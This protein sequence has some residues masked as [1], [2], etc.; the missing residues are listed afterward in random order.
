VLAVPPEHWPEFQALCDRELVEA[1]DLGQFVDSGRLTLR[2]E[3]HVVC[4]LSMD[5][6]H[7]GRPKVVRRA[8]FAKPEVREVA[9]PSQSDY[10]DDLIRVLRSW[11]VASKEWIIRQYDHEVQGRTV[12]KPL[13][14]VADDGPSDAAVVLPVRGS[15]RGLAVAC[16]LNPRYGRLDP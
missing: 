3:G 5:F 1:T 13:V 14:G 7:H 16:G 4:D 12:V 6:L 2:Y 10:T 15:T 8:R 9:L 11:D